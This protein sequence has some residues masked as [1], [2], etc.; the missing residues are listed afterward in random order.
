VNSCPG[1]IIAATAADI[2]TGTKEKRDTTATTE[3]ERGTERAVAME[4]VTDTVTAKAVAMERVTDTVTA[5][6]AATERVTDTVTAKAAATE[7]A[8]ARVA[9]TTTKNKG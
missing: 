8:T 5:K 7:K 9:A 1:S 2:A 6:A 4:R 3:R